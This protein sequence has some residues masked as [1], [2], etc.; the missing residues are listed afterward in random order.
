MRAVL[1]VGDNASWHTSQRVRTWSRD[2]NRQVKQQGCGGRILPCR[3]PSKSPWLNP[4]EP[5]WVHE[6]R[7][8][9]EPARVWP[10]HELADRVC[11][12]YGCAHEAY[13]SVSE[14]AA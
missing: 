4:T 12:S 9:M 2:H 7:A 10:A 3:R 5:K 13:L 6:K 14:K 1:L 8:V 11:A